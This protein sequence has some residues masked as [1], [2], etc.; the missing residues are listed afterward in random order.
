WRLCSSVTSDTSLETSSRRSVRRH[1]GSLA[2]SG[3][4]SKTATS[5]DMPNG[6]QKPKD[7]L[8]FLGRKN[9]GILGVHKTSQNPFCEVLEGAVQGES[10]LMPSPERRGPCPAARRT[11]TASPDARPQPNRRPTP[12]PP[13]PAAPRRPTTS[14]QRCVRPP[15][16]RT[17]GP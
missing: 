6:T 13:K 2:R 11:S 8:S 17:T 3:H 12:R 1:A 4:P 7:F 5:P 14:T 10:V 16:G 9:P 15:G